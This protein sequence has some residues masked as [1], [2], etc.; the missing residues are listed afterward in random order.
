M[1]CLKAWILEK[2][3]H[4]R[5]QDTTLLL[6]TCTGDTTFIK[7]LRTFL[8]DKLVRELPAFWSDGLGVLVLGWSGDARDQQRTSRA[9]ERE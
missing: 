6:H 3:T 7:L 5:K 8:R 2:Y 1:A 9:V 4:F